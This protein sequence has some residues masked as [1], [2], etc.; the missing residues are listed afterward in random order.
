MQLH[1]RNRSFINMKIFVDLHNEYVK[2]NSSRLGGHRLKP[3]TPKPVTES[4][5]EA[6]PDEQVAKLLNETLVERARR[7]L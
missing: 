3:R 5:L 7:S 2:Q 6:L 4:D 1:I